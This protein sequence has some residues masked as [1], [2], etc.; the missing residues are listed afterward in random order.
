MPRVVAALG[1]LPVRGLVTTGP[2]LE[3]DGRL[4]ANV[5]VRDWLPHAEVLP[6]TALVI[7]H[8]GMGTTMASLAHGVP[9]VC[10]PMGTDQ[11]E[12]TARVIHAGAG[13][14]CDADAD[15]ARIPAAIRAALGD[16]DLRAAARRLANAIADE[17]AADRAVSELEAL[18]AQTTTEKEAAW[19]R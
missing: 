13:L 16:P 5:E 3:L 7:T 19:I 18:A 9:L 8:A 14:R 2:A 6:F 1:T 4:P 10:M 12:V 17:I 11:H 15:E